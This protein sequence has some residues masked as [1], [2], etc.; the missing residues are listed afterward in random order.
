M[1][2]A[3]CQIKQVVM[4]LK[5]R[6][7]KRPRERPEQREGR[8]EGGREGESKWCAVQLRTS[9]ILCKVSPCSCTTV[10]RFLKMLPSSE[11]VLSIVEVVLSRSLRFFFFGFKR[12]KQGCT[13][14]PKKEVRVRISKRESWRYLWVSKRESWR[15]LLGPFNHP[16][17]P[18]A[19]ASKHQQTPTNPSRHT[20]A[21]TST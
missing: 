3:K 14:H 1:N 10:A 7:E 4:L 19:T 9:S 6:L 12:G 15:Y 17:C 8:R 5:T 11:I 16:A 2:Y 20:P 18:I 21:H 13:T